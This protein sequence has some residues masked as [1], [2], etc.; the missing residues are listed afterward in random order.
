MEVTGEPQPQRRGV[1]RVV[2]VMPSAF[3]LANLFFG[4]W[5][6]VWAS[7]GRLAWAG[8]FIVFAGILDMLDG[9]MARMSNTGSRFGAELDSLVDVVSFGV[10]PAFLLYFVEF[11]S[12]GRFGWLVCYF[13]VVAAALRLAR[14]NV[15][16]AAKPTPGWFTGLPS[17]AAGMTAATYYP[18]SQTEWY[19]RTM[20]YLNFEQQGLVVLLILL[21]MLMVSNVK[22]PRF[23]AIGF[24]GGAGIAGTIFL[25]I[26]LVGS[27]TAPESFL[28]PLG[29]VYLAFGIIRAAVLGFMQ[30]SDEHENGISRLTLNRGRAPWRRRRRQEPPPS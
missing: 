24:R 23:P 15:S 6:M 1:K 12:A 2:I 25:L 18:F 11:H 17:P 13:Y 27:I 4:I 3:T 29:I 28:F 16:S 21:S 30:P 14:Y 19:Q 5:S 7:Q 26:V 20:L 9:R 22:Y 10:A 8:W